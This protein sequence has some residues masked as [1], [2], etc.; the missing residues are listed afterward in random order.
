MRRD[1]R[2]IAMPSKDNPFPWKSQHDLMLRE[3]VDA[4]GISIARDIAKSNAEFLIHAAMFHEPL[5]NFVR[6]LAE[7]L[8]EADYQ[9]DMP[10]DLMSSV[11]NDAARLWAEMQESAK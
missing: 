6:R 2:G 7:W 3:I 10:H 8:K 1:L 4:D 5:A 11:I 9:A